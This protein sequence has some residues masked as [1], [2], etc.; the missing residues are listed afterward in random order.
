MRGLHVGSPRR[1][2]LLLWLRDGRAVRR[3]TRAVPHPELRLI[4]R[5]PRRLPRDVNAALGR[6][7]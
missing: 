2:Y 4:A 7:G 1:P 6:A 3:L 5:E